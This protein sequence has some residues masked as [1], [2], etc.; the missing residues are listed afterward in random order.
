MDETYARIGGQWHHIYRAI[1]GRG[2]IV[3]AYVSATRA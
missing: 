3:D 2:R 1:D